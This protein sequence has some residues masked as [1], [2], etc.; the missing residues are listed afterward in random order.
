MVYKHRICQ[1]IVRKYIDIVVG[2]DNIYKIERSVVIFVG[3]GVK[4][5]YMNK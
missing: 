4:G 2:F 1:L 5:L 3:F